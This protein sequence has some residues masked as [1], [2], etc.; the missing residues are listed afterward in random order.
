MI[1]IRTSTVASVLLAAA[2]ALCIG[3][4]AYLE[5]GALVTLGLLV[6]L[7]YLAIAG[8]AICTV[9]LWSA[10]R[11]V[12]EDP[13]NPNGY[14]RL[15]KALFD[16]GRAPEAIRVF[17]NVIQLDPSLDITQPREASRELER[18][19]GARDLRFIRSMC[20]L[21][22]MDYLVEEARRE[23]M[24][25]KDILAPAESESGGA[26]ELLAECAESLESVRAEIEELE[27]ACGECPGSEEGAER[28]MRLEDRIRFLRRL[29]DRVADLG[30]R[31][32]ERDL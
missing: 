26:A 13:T 32:E 25:L 17:R 3:V 1:R 2:L 21:A 15:A 30:K 7:R 28:R 8:V 10:R 4:C 9:P 20:A 24:K 12:A 11:A 14:Y 27:A 6:G 19:Y 18:R 22:S 16:K 5:A 23:S 31:I 29:A